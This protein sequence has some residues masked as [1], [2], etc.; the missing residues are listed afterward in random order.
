MTY[1]NEFGAPI[2]QHT[3]K[4]EPI[5]PNR[6]DNWKCKCGLKERQDELNKLYLSQSNDVQSS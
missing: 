5:H 2:L 1:R 6:M 4:C 3:A